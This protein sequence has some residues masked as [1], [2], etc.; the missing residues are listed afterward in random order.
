RKKILSLFMSS[1]MTVSLLTGCSG[2]GV[3]LDMSKNDEETSSDKDNSSDN[4]NESD[5]EKENDSDSNSSATDDAKASVESLFGTEGYPYD[6]DPSD[7]NPE[8]LKAHNI[9]LNPDLSDTSG[10]YSAL[11]IDFRTSD[12]AN[13]TYWALFNWNMH[14]GAGAYAG[15]QNAYNEKV[16]IMSFWKN[17]NTTDPEKEFATLI[18]P[19]DDTTDEFTNEGTGVKFIRSYSWEKDHWYRMVIR[20][21]D[22]EWTDSTVVEEWIQDK[23][24]GE[25]TLYAA[26]DTHIENSYLEG[27]IY[28]FMENFSASDC[29]ELRSWNL[30]NIYVMEY[31]S[32]KWTAIDTGL[33]ETDTTFNDKKGGYNFGATEDYFWGYTCGS[34]DDFVK[35]QT[36]LPTQDT[37]TIK[38]TDSA[39]DFDF[40]HDYGFET[41]VSSE[42]LYRIH[43]NWTYFDNYE[44]DTWREMG[45]EPYEND[46]YVDVSDGSSTID[47]TS[48]RCE[49]F[50]NTDTYYALINGTEEKIYS[51]TVSEEGYGIHIFRDDLTYNISWQTST[52]TIDTDC[53]A[54]IWDANDNYEVRNRDDYLARSYTGAW[55]FAICSVKNG[56]LGEFDYY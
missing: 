55:Y 5:D 27:K 43:V 47:I 16:A 4:K 56:V 44:E 26:Y 50:E 37:F 17:D 14:G 21:F 12:D 46:V 35:T 42:P 36:S 15:L 8:N 40:A 25:W 28:S 32:D 30:S 13:N 19:T 24:S 34:G 20:A 1:I 3:S 51:H 52:N 38:M 11:C 18:Y 45:V 23:E 39:P 31:G 49:T 9:Y 22:P 48:L 53:Y 10:K 6:I 33:L 29:N 54:E 41:T 2:S 7:P